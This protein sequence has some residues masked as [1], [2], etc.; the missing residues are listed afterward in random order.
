MVH[1]DRSRGMPLRPGDGVKG[2]R[3]QNPATTTAASTEVAQNCPT[4]RAVTAAGQTPLQANTCS[5][6]Y[7]AQIGSCRYMY[8]YLLLL[9][10]F[11]LLLLCHT[12]QHFTN[13]SAL[14]FCNLLFLLLF[15]SFACPFVCFLPSRQERGGQPMVMEAAGLLLLLR[16]ASC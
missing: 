12:L 7:R 6:H 9:K 1:G 5:M 11:L 10:P 15:C 14:C 4:R 16:K 13:S 8:T 2:L 3:Q